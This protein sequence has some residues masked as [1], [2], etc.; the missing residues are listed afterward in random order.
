MVGRTLECSVRET[1]AQ[2]A[3]DRWEVGHNIRRF[4][5]YCPGPYPEYLE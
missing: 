4:H 1:L 2:L 3:G 5:A